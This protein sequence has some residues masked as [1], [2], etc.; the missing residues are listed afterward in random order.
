MKKKTYEVRI[1]GCFE[2]VMRHCMKRSEG[3]WITEEMIGAYTRVHR[4]GFAHS[5]E[6]YCE[7]R[8]T[9]GLYGISMGGA[10]C[11]ESMFHLVSNHSKIALCELVHR[12]KRRKMIL[13]DAQFPNDHLKQ[14]NLE[15]IPDA[16]YYRKLQIALTLSTRFA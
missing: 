10:F 5:L 7:G 11:G 4:M 16:V 9:G 14:F 15:M 13:L 1:N 3:T 6:I 12:M 8:L 2:A